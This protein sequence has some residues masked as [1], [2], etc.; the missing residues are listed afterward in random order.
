[1]VFFYFQ[2]RGN[3]GRLGEQYIIHLFILSIHFDS[4]QFLISYFY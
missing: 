2:L 3:I 4:T 1:M